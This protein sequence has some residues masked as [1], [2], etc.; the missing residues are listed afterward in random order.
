MAF[1]VWIDDSI[2]LAEL[3]VGAGVAALG[4]LFAEIAQFQ[5]GIHL[6]V[7]LEMLSGAVR[8]P[9][10]IARDLAVVMSALWQKV[11][12]GK[13]PASGFAGVS[14]RRTDN[15]SEGVTWRALI[16]AGASIAPNT[17][18]LGI[19]EDRDVMIVHHLV[20]PRGVDRRPARTSGTRTRR[21]NGKGS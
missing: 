17:I 6:R 8:L 19:D 1:W 7:S 12:I 13:D 14:V 11:V 2:A 4:A 18:A 3:L 15:S 5:A 21:A 10:D 16:I 20:L 9:V